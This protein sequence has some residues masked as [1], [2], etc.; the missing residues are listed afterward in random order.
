MMICKI[1]AFSTDLKMIE[2][3]QKCAAEIES[4]RKLKTT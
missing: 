3:Y 1:K 4:L 2:Y